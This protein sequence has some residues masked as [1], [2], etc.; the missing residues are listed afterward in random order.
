MSENKTKQ[1]TA[2]KPVKGSRKKKKKRMSAKKKLCIIL[3]I[4]AVLA[5]LLIF[6]YIYLSK[7]NKVISKVNKVQTSD[8]D[9]NY[10]DD[11]NS[12]NL[13]KY[14]TF[15]VYG[16]DTRDMDKE[17]MSQAGTL[18]DV[19]MV[20]SIEEATKDVRMLS[21]YRDTYLKIDDS[22][23]DKINAAYSYAFSSKKNKIDKSNLSEDEIS[24]EQMKYAINALNNNLDLKINRFVAVNFG[25]VADIIDELGGIEMEVTSKEIK[26]TDGRGDFGIN[27]YIDEI[28]ERTGSKAKHITT[29]GVQHLNGVQAT[30]YARI[31]KIDTD[32]E[33]TNRQRKVVTAMLDK[34]KA[35][36]IDK[37]IDIAELVA[38]DMF[39]NFT[40]K[41]I[42]KRVM[43]VLSY[44][45]VAQDGFPF[46]KTSGGLNGSGSYVFAT[47]LT[48]NVK[49][50]H[51][52]LYEDESYEPT[53]TVTKIDAEIAKKRG[54][55]SNSTTTNSN[56]T[57]NSSKTT[58]QKTSSNES[59]E[60]TSSEVSSAENTDSTNSSTSESSSTSSSSFSS[61]VTITSKTVEET[62]TISDSS[63][64]SSQSSSSDSASSDN[65]EN[66]G[67][68]SSD[69]T[70]FSGGW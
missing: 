65:T 32:Y 1:Q 68:F 4:L 33:R 59:A 12:E 21:V 38:Q 34:A 49:Q 28:N 41:E 60:D 20:I 35:A 37:C 17:S 2:A 24:L 67:S 10:N 22:N 40:T 39:T 19:I 18:S 11:I 15:V 25:I 13:D 70:M 47:D 14:F 9:F 30:A 5:I 7:Y 69:G 62:T 23:Y 63:E 44:N 8:D 3:P 6:G 43:D 54:L 36:G 57:T 16:L 48:N 26:G 66:S 56:T 58:N 64:D 45:I 61:S 46:E 53:E 55:K 42:N 51:Q 52:F 27:A 31:R 29:P 50:L